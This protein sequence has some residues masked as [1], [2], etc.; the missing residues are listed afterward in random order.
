VHAR[1]AAAAVDPAVL[2]VSLDAKATVKI[3]PFSRGGTSRGSVQA[4][5]HDF[6]P[7]G[8]VTPVGIFLPE[9]DELS[10]YQVISKVTSDC[11]VDRLCPWWEGVRDRFAQISMLV[12]NLDHGPEHHRQRTPCMYRLVA[13]VAP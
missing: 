5:D 2:R 13:F 6:H 4:A 11:L 3:G 8:R 9:W 7:A 1:N 12:L 10:I